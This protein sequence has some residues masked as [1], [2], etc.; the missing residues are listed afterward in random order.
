LRAAGAIRLN[1]NHQIA[2]DDVDKLR[3]IAEQSSV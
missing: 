3:R 2:I 1:T